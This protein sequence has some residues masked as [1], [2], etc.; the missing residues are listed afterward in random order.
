MII[1]YKDKVV[2]L[3]MAV[4]WVKP[5][6]TTIRIIYDREFTDLV[7]SCK[8][9]RDEYWERLDRH[10]TYAFNFDDTKWNLPQDK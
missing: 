2:N 9:E 10:T 4:Y 3:A 6:S 8:E 5:T 7:F 1:K